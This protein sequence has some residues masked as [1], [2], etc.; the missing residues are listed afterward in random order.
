MVVPV[1]MSMSPLPDEEEPVVMAT[2][3]EVPDAAVPE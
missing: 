3:P 2:A 1:L